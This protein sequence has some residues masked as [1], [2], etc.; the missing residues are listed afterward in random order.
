MDLSAINAGNETR[1]QEVG[2][3]SKAVWTLKD[4]LLVTLIIF[5]GPIIISPPVLRILHIVVRSQIAN[6]HI[7][8]SVGSIFM[9]FV[10]ILWTKTKYGTGKRS[11]G[12]RKGR[13]RIVPTILMGI[14]AGVIY[15]VLE[16][17]ISG[18][19][20][21]VNR[22]VGEH[23]LDF[24]STWFIF[25]V[26]GTSVL[27]PI[28]QEVYFRGFMYGYLRGILGKKLGL[29]AQSL[30]FTLLHIDF[31]LA[32]SI[33]LFLQ[34]FFAGILLGLIYE[35]SDSIYPSIACHVIVNSLYIF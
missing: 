24:F 31:I 15:F 17:L 25:R 20:L 1:P 2:L 21:L 27:S 13:W 9:I 26:L 7:F 34:R 16:S 8:I 22:F 32:A 4:I 5:I 10:P 35:A 33:G 19:S 6:V 23:G 18:R 28:G 12:V 29:I 11:L 14:G 30:V 3:F